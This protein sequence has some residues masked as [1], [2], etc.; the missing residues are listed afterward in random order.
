MAYVLRRNEDGKF[1]T[2]PGSAKSY[3]TRIENARRFATLEE[4][5]RNKC[6]NETAIR[7]A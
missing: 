7:V 4:A 6:G 5:N 2:A 1:V 3:T